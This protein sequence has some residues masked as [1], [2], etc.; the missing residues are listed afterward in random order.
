MGVDVGLGA[1]T[2][3][4]VLILKSRLITERIPLGVSALEPTTVIPL[5]VAVNTDWSSLSL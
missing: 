3:I 1:K 4:V 5:H 2:E